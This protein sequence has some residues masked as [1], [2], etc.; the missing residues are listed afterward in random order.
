MLLGNVADRPVRTLSGGQRR[1]VHCAMAT[2]GRPPLLLLDEP[3][4]GVDPAT[5]RALLSHVRALAA[6]G[7]AVCYSTHYLPEIEALAA[8]VVMLKD[9]VVATRGSVAELVDRFGR[10]VIDLRIAGDYPAAPRTLSLEVGGPD[11]LPAVLHGLGADLQR[12]VSL[13][14]RRS[15]L[16]EVFHRVVDVERSPVDAG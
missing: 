16:D 11:A 15:N 1:R 13:D 2:V 9:G 12:L 3:T 6:E 8:D 5:R 10:T 4:V 14:V 7:T